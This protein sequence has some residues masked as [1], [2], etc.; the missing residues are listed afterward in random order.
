M[1]AALTYNT[2]CNSESSQEKSYNISRKNKAIFYNT[3]IKRKHN[4]L[5]SEVNIISTDVQRL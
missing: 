4:I 5:G 2:G 3:N 1:N